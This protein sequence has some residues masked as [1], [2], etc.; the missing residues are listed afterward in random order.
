MSTL[1]KKLENKLI[2]DPSVKKGVKKYGIYEFF[3]YEL[4]PSIGS[5]F[6]F[7]VNN[8]T[9]AVSGSMINSYVTGLNYSTSQPITI[10]SLGGV[11]TGTSPNSFF[12]IKNDMILGRNLLFTN[13]NTTVNIITNTLV[14]ANINFTIFVSIDNGRTYS[15]SPYMVCTLL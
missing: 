2:E 4:D 9:V 7:A 13:L 3:I 11:I 8:I 15:N 5:S 14:N 10:T 6:Q 1:N 12:P